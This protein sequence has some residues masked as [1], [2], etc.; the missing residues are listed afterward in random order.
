MIFGITSVAG[1]RVETF[2]NLSMGGGT[3]QRSLLS[4]I[5]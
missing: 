1:A 3:V 2:N 5:R 4:T